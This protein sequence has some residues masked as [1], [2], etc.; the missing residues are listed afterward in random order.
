MSG[1]T[2]ARTLV[3]NTLPVPPLSSP[4][5]P[6]PLL[7]SPALPWDSTH[8]FDR[9]GLTKLIERARAQLGRK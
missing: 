1:L 7:P 4:P 8:F 5:L 3:A 9:V 2:R 6:C